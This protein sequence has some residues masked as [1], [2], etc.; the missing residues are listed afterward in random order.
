MHRLENETQMSQMIA[1]AQAWQPPYIFI[2]RDVAGAGLLPSLAEQMG[3]VTLGTE[4]G[5]KA[6]FG[7]E[8]LRIAETGVHNTLHWAGVL[9]QAWPNPRPGDCLIVEADDVRDYVMAPVSGIYEPLTEIGDRVESGQLLGQIHSLEQIDR[10]AEEVRAET[11]GIVF[12]RRS[13][14]LTAQ[15]ECLATIVREVR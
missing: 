2:Y 6:Q 14:P 13:I 1:A 7:V 15:G 9:E 5:S 10:D 4:I 3:K 11:S 12:C 8:M